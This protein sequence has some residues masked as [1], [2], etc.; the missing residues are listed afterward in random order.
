MFIRLKPGSYFSPRT[1]DWPERRYTSL[2]PLTLGEE[3]ITLV[4]E[5]L[6]PE[7]WYV[8]S[9]LLFYEANK[10]ELKT[11]SLD[12]IYSS[13][14]SKISRDQFDKALIEL[15]STYITR[16]LIPILQWAQEGL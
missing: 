1:M 13:H 7:A 12:Y 3:T 4:R 2:Q 15:Q 9:I 6:S 10:Y 11:P 14:C 8:Y 16:D 5:H